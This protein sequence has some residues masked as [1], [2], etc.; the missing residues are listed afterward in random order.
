[1]RLLL[2][3]DERDLNR[4]LSKKLTDEGYSVDSA[5]DGEEAL[6]FLDA[7]DYDGVILDVMMPKADGF[8]VLRSL[9]SE[10]KGVP[11][12]MLTA[13]D[14]IS[15]RV[16]GLDLGANDYLIKPFSM[17]ELMARVRALTRQVHQAQTSVLTCR[18]L[19]LDLSTHKA[20]RGGREIELSTK[21]FAL[22]S[23]LMKNQNV[24]LS[25]EMIE[26]H[27]WNFDY[28]GGT[29]VID[30]YIRYLRKKI[31]DDFEVKLIQTIR[32]SGYMLK[33]ESQSAE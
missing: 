8:E 20:K 14:A 2:A 12:L 28:E 19:S 15:D 29:N 1:M 5:F 9:R 27:I 30:V 32:G 24:V 25:R 23:Y 16:K 13:R 26:N 4:I 22:L 10:G 11:V 18:D 3:E 7:A 21:E 6:D 31:D 33:G 17:D